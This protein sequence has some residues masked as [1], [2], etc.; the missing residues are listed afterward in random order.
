[1]LVS[2][3]RNV[4]NYVNGVETMELFQIILAAFRQEIFHFW[5][6]DNRH[7]EREMGS[8]EC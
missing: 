5:K 6:Y 3:A 7:T 8:I 4:K 2:L 1:M